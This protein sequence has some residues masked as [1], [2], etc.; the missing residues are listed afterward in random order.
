[1]NISVRCPSCGSHFD[2]DI[3]LQRTETVC[4]SCTEGFHASSVLS[5][6][7][8]DQLAAHGHAATSGPAA[9]STMAATFGGTFG[10]FQL[11]NQLA[12]N[13]YWITYRARDPQ[14][15]QIVL[16][17][18]LVGESAEAAAEIS[19]ICYRLD[20]I[21]DVLHPNL[22]QIYRIGAVEY[23]NYA[24]SEF[25][26]GQRLS[27]MA[28]SD[29][30]PLTK[31]LSLIQELCLAVEMLHAEGWIHGGLDSNSIILDGQGTP[32]IV[33]LGL[34][35]DPV[36]QDSNVPGRVAPMP[37]Y[38]APE[39]L[40]G[41]EPTAATD[42]YG[43]G[44]LLYHLV[45]GRPPFVAGDPLQLLMKIETQAPIAPREINPHVPKDVELI[46]LKCL[47]KHPAD[48]YL[49]V[50]ALYRDID[51]AIQGD[52]VRARPVPSM[53][54]A[55]RSVRRSLLP[56]LRL[57]MLLAALGL[58]G[59]YGYQ[60]YL[61]RLLQSARA[62]EK[63]EDFQS[64]EQQ[65]SQALRLPFHQRKLTPYLR[66]GSVRFQQGNYAEA[67]QD[68]A[69]AVKL[70]AD[71]DSRDVHYALAMTRWHAAVQTQDP[72][73]R[74]QLLQGAQEALKKYLKAGNGEDRAKIEAFLSALSAQLAQLDGDGNR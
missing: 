59:W 18:V 51:R 55:T 30:V 70:A 21:K 39:R 14:Q 49:T 73:R 11:I 31:A 67:E 68:F 50:T 35:R 5:E 19:Q 58:A 29:Q 46:A 60:A 63:S 47:E 61:E 34:A 16:L 22:A 74:Q 26:H 44:C 37:A 45:T 12:K 9:E 4:P 57:L 27:A 42:V 7:D 65:Y 64:A 71:A 2:A 43:L 62:H 23:V 66:R 15:Q 20:R 33:D 53:R 69:A 25:V 36:P 52:A 40:A 10:P 28:E 48:R 6:K 24:A 17:R 1:M 54:R 41:R 32:K 56:V 3:T 72:E 38:C 13:D 8:W